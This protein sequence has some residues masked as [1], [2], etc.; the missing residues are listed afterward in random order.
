MISHEEWGSRRKIIYLL[1]ETLQKD[2]DFKNGV[3]MV[4]MKIPGLGQTLSSDLDYMN[5]N[6]YFSSALHFTCLL[7]KMKVTS[8]SV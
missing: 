2:L 4:F 6:V 5:V 7:R 1:T 3:F 8:S